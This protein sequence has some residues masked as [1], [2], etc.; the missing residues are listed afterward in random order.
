MDQAAWKTTLGASRDCVG[1]GACMQVCPVYRAGRREELSARGKLRLI[2][3]LAQGPLPPSRRLGEILSRCLLCGRCSQNCPN[4]VPAMEG[5]RAGRE[6][7]ASVAGV[8]LL[9]RLL[10]D[11]ALPHPERL[12]MLAMAGGL[13]LPLLSGLRLRLGGLEPGSCLPPLSQRPFLD[14]APRLLPGPAGSPRLGLFVGCVANYLRP[15]LARQ[16]ASLLSR[17]ATVV[18]PPQGCCGLAAVGAGLAASAREMLASTVAA[19]TRAGVDKIVTVCGSCAYALAQELPRLLDTPQARALAGSVLEIS[20]VLVEHPR[21]L[22][23]LGRAGGPVAVHDP[24]HLK[25][26][27]KVHEEPRQML[28]RAGV[29]LVEMEQ[30]DAC[31]GG[32]GLF[33]VNHPELSRGILEP[34]TQAFMHSGARLLATSCS[35]CHLQWQSGLP[36]AYP[37]RHPIELL[38]RP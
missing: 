16:A 2:Q 6:V 14:T 11:Q 30:A 1:C 19:F 34:R 29:E 24:C 38:N 18:V 8:P 12:E 27:L 23:G 31:C 22:A 17:V 15:Q 36:A 33:A 25:L 9:L 37:V 21:L 35:G 3:A 7:L 26:G 13:A 32:G 4:Q 5:L 28:R 10:V 20:Q